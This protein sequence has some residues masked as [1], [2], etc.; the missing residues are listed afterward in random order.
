MT[1]TT[2]SSPRR[3]RTVRFRALV[4][5]SAIVTAAA[6]L[7]GC[8]GSGGDG[9]SKTVSFLSWDN[10]ATMKPV[11]DE[12]QKENSGYT[13]KFSY[14]PPVPQ[15]IQKLQTL[16]GS[17]S[18]PDV[19]II[20]A[21]NKTQIMNGGFA[22]DLSKESWIDNI[23]P[24]ARAT[25]TKDGKV[26]GAATASWGGGFLVNTDLLAK[27][28]YTGS[29]QTWQEFL[30]LAKKLKD[31]GITP[32]LEAADGVSTLLS[33]MLGVENASLDGKMDEQ[34]WAGKTTFA[35]TWTPSLKTWNE[36]FEQD[37][38]TRSVAGLTGD[39]VLQQFEQGKVAMISTGSWALGGIQQAAPNLKLK[40]LP[41]PNAQ[42]EKYWGG[43]VAPGFAINAKAK[44]PAAA[45]K[46]VQFLQSK[47]GVEIAQKQT[48]SITTTADFEPKLDPALDLMV[49]D[50]RDGK[51]YLPAVS[52][53]D[54]SDV[55]S[56]EAVALI[57]Q[58]ASGKISP[59]DVAKGLDKKLASIK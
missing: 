32:F 10:A 21:E 44:N 30:D 57:Q 3:R 33:A 7:T 47:K 20:T 49:K 53:P 56:T 9:G 40:Y 24:A 58:M 14:A 22:K 16:L 37:L 36:L 35:K 34:I 54:H 42:G 19:F 2:L 6:A 48:Q 51:F 43:A 26:Y 29:P 23:A 28:G 12:F 4:A 11:I 17:G 39:Q 31:A 18:A 41:V 45:E 5:I 55:M 1:L 38:E 50:V 15:Y 59:E 52:W 13:V 27:V 46:F 25:Y 8:S